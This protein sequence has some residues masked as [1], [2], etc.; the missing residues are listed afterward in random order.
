VGQKT[1]VVCTKE[2]CQRRITFQIGDIGKILVSVRRTADQGNAVIFDSEP[3]ILF[4]DGQKAGLQVESGV[5]V[6]PIQYRAAGQSGTKTS[7]PTISERLGE[8][9]PKKTTTKYQPDAMEVD[10]LSGPKYFSTGA[11]SSARKQSPQ[12]PATGFR[13]QVS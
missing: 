1:V 4:S 12:G 7:P 11:D 2:G 13:R 6:L 5:Y 3:R 8:Q 10:V 9:K